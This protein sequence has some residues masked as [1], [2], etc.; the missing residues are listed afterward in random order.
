MI[1]Q[2]LP[3]YKDLN[4]SYFIRKKC[5]Y[6]NKTIVSSLVNLPSFILT[7]DT[8]IDNTFTFEQIDKD[9]NVCTSFT[10]NETPCLTSVYIDNV[11]SDLVAFDVASFL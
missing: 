4:D 6:S 2:P 5:D 10:V 1:V 3:I 8:S 11:I 7:R 9:G